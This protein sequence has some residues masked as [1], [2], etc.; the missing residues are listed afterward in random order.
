MQK[1]FISRKLNPSSPLWELSDRYE[2]IDQSLIEIHPVLVDYL[3]EAD[4]IF[5]YSQT[6]VK[7][8]F[9]QFISNPKLKCVLFGAFGPKTS[10][11]IQEYGFHVAFTGN[12]K[13]VETGPAFDLVA[14]NKKVLFPRANY[15]SRSLQKILGKKI[16]AID[17]VVYNNDVLEKIDLPDPDIL[18]FTSPLNA[19]SY[20]STK[21]IREKQIVIAI[22]ETTAKKL[23][24]LGIQDAMIPNSPTEESILSC[25]SNLYVR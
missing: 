3:P 25:I 10:S 21:Q 6:G 17:L 20:F 5:F 13:S 9:D 16:Q 12:G 22:G 24:S 1:L 11:C 19:K 23:K 7:I 2:I 8:F 14:R 18:V 4:W 15:S